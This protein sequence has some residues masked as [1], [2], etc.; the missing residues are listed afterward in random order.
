[1]IIPLVFN[2]QWVW[3]DRGRKE[4]K[5]EMLWESH[6]APVVLTATAKVN[7]DNFNYF[8]RCTR[9]HVSN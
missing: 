4:A 1:M 9:D 7:A 2:I 3:E 5:A 8:T 6:Q